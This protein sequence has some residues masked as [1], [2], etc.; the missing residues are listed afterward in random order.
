[1]PSQNQW[2]EVYEEIKAAEM[3]LF[4]TLVTGAALEEHMES[5]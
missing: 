4:D 3:A 5:E 1:L 2:E